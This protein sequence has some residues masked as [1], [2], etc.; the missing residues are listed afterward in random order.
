MESELWNCEASIH[1]KKSSIA[2]DAVPHWVCFLE[3]AVKY[4]ADRSSFFV[5]HY[6]GEIFPL[7]PLWT[8]K[9][10]GRV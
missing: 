1:F 6:S 7:L 8:L 9:N 5:R 3:E 2:D 4:A 10:D